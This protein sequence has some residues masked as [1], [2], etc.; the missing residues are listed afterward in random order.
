MEY[1][2]IMSVVKM[3]RERFE[4]EGIPKRRLDPDSFFL[5]K[6]EMLA[7]AHYLL[8]GIERYAGN[9]EKAGKTGRHLGSVQTLLWVAQWYTL[10]ELREHNSS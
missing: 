1:G 7:H 10:N 2:E 5:S 8:D 4:K 6:R 3:Y 9:P